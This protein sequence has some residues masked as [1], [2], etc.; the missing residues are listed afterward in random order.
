MPEIKALLT[1]KV[2]IP[3]ASGAV[4]LIAATFVAVFYIRN[5]TVAEN[6]FSHDGETTTT[7]DDDRRLHAGTVAGVPHPSTSSA[8]SVM[9]TT[10]EPPA[11]GISATTS[12]SG[13]STTSH[14]TM[15]STIT[16][17]AA[18]GHPGNL[19]SS[20]STVHAIEPTKREK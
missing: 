5:P 8:H 10:R 3:V 19:D 9:M 18:S 1:P 7:T 14:A 2:A 15:M 6:L 20:A 17:G 12:S 13:S 4:L 11:N 16:A